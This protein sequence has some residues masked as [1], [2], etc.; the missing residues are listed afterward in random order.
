M[1]IVGAGDT[2]PIIYIKLR[3]SAT[4]FAKTG[5]AFNTGGAYCSYTR[6]A[7]ASVDITL[8]TQ[9][10]TG[11]WTSGGFV[12]QHNTKAKGLYRLDLP[13][14][15]AAI[16]VGYTMISIGFT[17]V[18]DEVCQ[19]ILDV[20]PDVRTGLVVTDSGNTTTTFKTNLTNTNDNF[21]LDSF[22]LFRTGNLVDQGRRITAYNGTTKFITVSKPY[23]GIP[24]NNEGFTL[25]NR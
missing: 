16:G 3:D 11:V 14:G 5:L 13:S 12:E 21:C 17:G 25:V 6:P 10:V 24:L 1:F 20:L 2:Q 8:A 23:T 4:G 7:S 9:T 15:A 19:V 22:A 18:L